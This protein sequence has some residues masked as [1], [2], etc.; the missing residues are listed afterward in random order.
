MN[1]WKILRVSL[2]ICTEIITFPAKSSV[3][4][5]HIKFRNVFW[6]RTVMKKCSCLIL[7]LWNNYHSPYLFTMIPWFYYLLSLESIASNVVYTLQFQLILKKL[8]KIQAKTSILHICSHY[9]RGS[10]LEDVLFSKFITDHKKSRG[11]NFP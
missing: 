1:E 9:N 6:I 11:R 5:L 4:L 7:V 3:H 2:K 8:Y 10:D